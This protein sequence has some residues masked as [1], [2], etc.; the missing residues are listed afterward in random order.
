MLLLTCIDIFAVS[1]LSMHVLVSFWS[2]CYFG[3]ISQEVSIDTFSYLSTFWF[4]ILPFHFKVIYPIH[5]HEDGRGQGAW[6]FV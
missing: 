2:F 5:G 1:H 4:T 6:G 3:A